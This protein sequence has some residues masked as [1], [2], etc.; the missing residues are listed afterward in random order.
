MGLRN[1]S[2]SLK[3]TLRGTKDS[4]RRFKAPKGM[5]GSLKGASRG[6][7]GFQRVEVAFLGVSGDDLLVPDL[8]V[9]EGLWGFR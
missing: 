8:G 9:S 3:G 7:K 4:H 5:L 6:L 2:E 1:V